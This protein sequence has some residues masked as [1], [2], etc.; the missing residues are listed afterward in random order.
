MQKKDVLRA[1]IGAI[2]IGAPVLAQPGAVYTM[3]NDA[4]SNAVIAYS[5][6]G[7]GALSEA[8]VYP[9]GGSGTGAG[10]GSQ[11]SVVLSKNGRWLLAVNAGSND[12]SVFRVSR[13]GL[14]LTDVEASLGEMPT[15]VA[16]DGNLVYVLNAAGAGGIQGFWLDAQGD[17]SPI[18]GSARPLSGADMTAA[19]QVGFS[20][21]G[22]TIVVTERATSLIDT[23]AVWIDG[24]TEGP[25]VSRSAG[26][27]PFGFDFRSDGLLLVSEAFGGM[28]DASAAS[29]YGIFRDG[30][31]G[32][33]SA[34]VPTTETAACWLVVSQ[35]GK[36]AYTTNTGSASVTGYAVDPRTGA[37]SRLDR[38]GVTGETGAGPIDASFSRGGRFLYTLDAASDTIS[39][40]RVNPANG[41]LHGVQTLKG[42]PGSSVGIAAD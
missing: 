10:L 25:F 13:Q 9:T 35:N 41:S 19:A 21:D 39:V 1:G 28:E 15:S 40:F 37:L 20:P 5:R 24:T 33:I 42:L 27:T 11:G 14:V 2:A 7:N 12:V 32:V 30:G 4:R 16:I 36:F 18:E 26:Q 31:L 34:S 3:S 6:G 8:G 38:D 23:Y 17:L 29:S 22:S